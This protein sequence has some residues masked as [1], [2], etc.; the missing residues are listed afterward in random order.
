MKDLGGASD[1]S[2]GEVHCGEDVQMPN[3]LDDILKIVPPMT[4]LQL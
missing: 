3:C 2:D 4:T 1:L